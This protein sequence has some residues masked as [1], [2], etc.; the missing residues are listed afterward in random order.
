MF[1][2]RR[3]FSCEVLIA[4]TH[5]TPS[6]HFYLLSFLHY[7]GDEEMPEEAKS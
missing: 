4:E 2:L 1:S 6:D 3:Q 5:S 7:K